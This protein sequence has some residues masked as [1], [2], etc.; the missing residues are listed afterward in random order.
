MALVGIPAR[1]AAL[2]LFWPGCLAVN[3][4]YRRRCCVWGRCVIR[5]SQQQKQGA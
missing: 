5:Y 1:P 4:V 3:I 2:M